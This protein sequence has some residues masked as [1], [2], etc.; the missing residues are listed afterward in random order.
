MRV[1]YMSAWSGRP[2]VR[3]FSDWRAMWQF[4][5]ARLLWSSV[6]QLAEEVL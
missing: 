4:V 5:G 6:E 2:C 3:E 1:Q